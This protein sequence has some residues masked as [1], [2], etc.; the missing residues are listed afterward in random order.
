[1]KRETKFISESSEQGAPF[2][3]E[4]L[5]WNVEQ[6]SNRAGLSFR[7]LIR[8]NIELL[9][10]RRRGMRSSINGRPSTSATLPVITPPATSSKSI[11]STVSSATMTIA[12]PVALAG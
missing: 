7:F 6:G 8:C 1:V 2:K 10:N 9:A 5:K 3:T 11:S 12:L 4:R